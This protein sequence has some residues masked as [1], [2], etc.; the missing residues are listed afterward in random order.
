MPFFVVKGTFHIKG[1]SPDGD[2]VRFRADN[3]E[4]W[5]KLSG[6][7]VELNAKDHAQLR[8]EAIDTLETHYRD[9]HQPL[10]MAIGAL[11]HLLEG[12]GITDVEWNEAR[13][14][15][16]AANDGTEGYVLSRAVE[17]N[18]RPVSFV[19]VGEPPEEDG[20]E[21][22]LDADRMRQSLNHRALE[23]GVAYPTYYE[24]LFH[25]LREA[26]TEAVGN[27]REAKRGVWA[28]DRTNAGFEVEGLGSIT[29][30]HVVLPKLF[31]RLAEYLEGG[32]PVAGFEEF[33]EAKDEE[34]IIISTVHPTH[35]DT[36]VEVEGDTV[37]MT[38]PPENLIFE[39]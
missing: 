21:V 31:R 22:F 25:D 28:E 11:E 38:E 39:G 20:S 12:L 16:T 7:S 24:G 3:K 2:S 13:T 5:A 36:M 35:F 37:R 34:V 30:E 8:F 23:E 6:P 18:G 26:L 29:D 14:R 4:Y 10:E 1:Y 9:T 32:G 17:K 33:L 19:Y 27:A 15:V